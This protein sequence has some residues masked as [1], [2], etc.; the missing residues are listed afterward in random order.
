MF[1]HTDDKW[2]TSRAL[3]YEIPGLKFVYT[4]PLD[5]VHR[6][7]RVWKT[8]AYD[9]F[10]TLDLNDDQLFKVKS[11]AHNRVKQVYE[12]DAKKWHKEV[13]N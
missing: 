10:D 11:K 1:N 3:W 2:G 13:S 6:R 5:Q 9:M 8:Y 7:D 4:I 12:E